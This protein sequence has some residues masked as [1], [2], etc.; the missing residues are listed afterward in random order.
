METS[1]WY[2]DPLEGSRFVGEAGHFLDVFSFI[3]RSRPVSVVARSLRPQH[4]TQGNR[5][6][7]T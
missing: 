5:C 6:Q 3:T 2:L 4:I 7:F 1:S